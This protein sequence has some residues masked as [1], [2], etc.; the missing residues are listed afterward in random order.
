MDKNVKAQVTFVE[1]NKFRARGLLSGAEVYIDKREED[2]TPAGPNS[3]E[4]FLS[5][6][7]GCIAVY[8]KS[9]LRR[10]NITFNK[11][12]VDVEAKFSQTPPLHLANI[13]VKVDTDADLGEKFEVFLRFIKN[14]PIHNTLIHTNEVDIEI[15]P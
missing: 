14:C 7:G 9:Y 10:H 1:K 13:K 3:V 11:L 2:Y 15:V 4:L 6:L 8:G 12:D 5:S